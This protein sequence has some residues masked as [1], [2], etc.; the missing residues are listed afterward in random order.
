MVYGLEKLGLLAWNVRAMYPAD[1]GA[2]RIAM[3][4]KAYLRSVW[5]RYYVVCLQE[6]HIDQ[7]TVSRLY[8]W[9]AKHQRQAFV[10]FACEDPLKY[11]FEFLLYW[12]VA[13]LV[14]NDFASQYRLESDEILL[15]RSKMDAS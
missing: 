15:E 3:R 2:G 10:S 12:G 4:N 1:P 6:I 11:W 7:A 9:C 5:A 14:R 8:T 13:F